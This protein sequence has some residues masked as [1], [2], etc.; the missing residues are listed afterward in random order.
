MG[1]QYTLSKT[2]IAEHD[3]LLLNR[4]ADEENPLESMDIYLLMILLI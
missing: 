4:A 1:G 3:H 2:K